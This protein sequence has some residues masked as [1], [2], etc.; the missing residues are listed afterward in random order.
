MSDEDRAVWDERYRGLAAN[1]D[2]RVESPSE[3]FVRHA[4]VL[5]TAGRALD[6]GG[7]AGRN[8]IWLASRGLD[9]TIVDISAAGLAA[10]AV[11]AGTAG[12]ALTTCELD[13]ERS[14]LPAGPFN[15]VLCS[16][17]L[18]R[19]R[20]AEVPERLAPRGVFLM[21]HPTLR[22]LERHPRPGRR[23]LLDDG[24]LANL[25]P[26]LAIHHYREG[27]NPEG[28]YEAEIIAVK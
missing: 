10:A 21:T 6:I 17:F 25:I 13:L 24:E 27:W 1:P 4:H 9:V 12:V 23:F 28:R 22:N 18:L 15:V 8:A 20:V 16:H 3:F 14:P 7:G 26:G 5:P 2:Y 19:D 11:A